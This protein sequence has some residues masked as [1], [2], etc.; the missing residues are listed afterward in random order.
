[1]PRGEEAQ[2]ACRGLGRVS[3]LG[4]VLYTTAR[5][6]KATDL[7]L[8]RALRPGVDMGSSST[9]V[10]SPKP[11]EL[12]RLA[13][14]NLLLPEKLGENGRKASLSGI[15]LTNNVSTFLKPN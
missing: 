3:H 4:P 2:A 1:M 13:D 7:S 10:T 15:H 11:K 8:P 6:A 5:L 9:V 14:F 12:A